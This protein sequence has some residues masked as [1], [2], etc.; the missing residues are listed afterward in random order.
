MVT[1]FVGNNSNIWKFSYDST[2]GVNKVMS[3]VIGR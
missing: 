1:G 3:G 2:H